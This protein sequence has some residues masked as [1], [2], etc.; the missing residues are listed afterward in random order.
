MT[1]AMRF[2]RALLGSGCFGGREESLEGRRRIS[3]ISRK[4]F[5]ERRR[6]TEASDSDQSWFIRIR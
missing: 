3:P 1:V 6:I 4:D 2:T 5:Q